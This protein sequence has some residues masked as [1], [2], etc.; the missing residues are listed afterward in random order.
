MYMRLPR[1]TSLRRSLIP[2]AA[3]CLVSAPAWA[4]GGDLLVAPTRLILDPGRGTE[5]VLNNVGST[6][7]TFRI[8]LELRRMTAEGTLEDVAPDQANAVE[9]AIVSMVSFSPRKV[10]LPPNLPQVIRVG[11]RAPA[12]LP[13][14]EYR[15]HMLFRAIPDAVAAAPPGAPKEGVSIS[16][17]PIYGVTI[18]IIVRKGNLLATASLSD[19]KLAT[20]DDKPAIEFSISRVGT[21]STYGTIRVMRPG[22]SK[23]LMEAKGIAV[24]PEIAKRSVLLPVTPEVAATLAGPVTI[25]YIEESE[26]GGKL[27]AELKTVL[28]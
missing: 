26:V 20:S 24:Y 12:D 9:K 28:R 10:V 5:I 16:L 8:S 25:Q 21:R 6:P 17:T 14:G 4:G 19:A 7:A 18:P 15:G 22:V 1:L 13:D 27:L 11:I 23:P 3:I 2:L